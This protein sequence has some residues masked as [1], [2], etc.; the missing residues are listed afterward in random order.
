MQA[1]KNDYIN[2]QNNLSNDT[3]R[4]VSPSDLVYKSQKFAKVK[5]VVSLP[6]NFGS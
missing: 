4:H 3:G 6:K 1:D 5:L 2:I